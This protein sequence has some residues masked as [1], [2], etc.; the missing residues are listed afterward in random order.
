[1][2]KKNMQ[3]LC[4]DPMCPACLDDDGEAAFWDEFY[5]REEQ[6]E[7][8]ELGAKYEVKVIDK[9]TG[10]EIDLPAVTELKRRIKRWD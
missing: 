10:E 7:L 5:F 4:E 9:Q 6:S 8:E 2:P 1:M 3:D